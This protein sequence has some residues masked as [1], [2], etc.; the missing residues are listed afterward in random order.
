MHRKVE[1]R[2]PERGASVVEMVVFMAI[3]TLIFLAVLDANITYQRTLIRNEARAKVQDDG[4][5]TLEQ[6]LREIRMAGYGVP[7]ADDPAS[8]SPISAAAATSVSFLTTEGGVSTNLTAPANVGDTILNVASTAGFQVTN[9]IYVVDEAHYRAATVTAVGVNTLTVTPAIPAP[10]PPAT[11]GG[12]TTGATVARQPRTVTYSLAGG[13]L[14]RDRGDGAGP[15]PVV[16]GVSSLA[17][18]YF[19]GNNTAVVFPGG[20][21]A[22]IRRVAVNMTV[23][24]TPRGQPSLSFIARSDIRI[25]NR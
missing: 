11:T 19:D 1:D 12:F 7:T 3:F 10:V 9:P 23:S 6:V 24:T 20:D 8:L 14:S 15:L 13:V 18:S 4:R 5:R 16:T 2:H 22:S 17:F 25:R 21:V